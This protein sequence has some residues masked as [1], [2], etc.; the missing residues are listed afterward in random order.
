MPRLAPLP[1]LAYFSLWKDSVRT[2]A[3][4]RRYGF[5]TKSLPHNKSRLVRFRAESELSEPIWQSLQCA[6]SVADVCCVLFVHFHGG[7]FGLNKDHKVSPF[8]GDLLDKMFC[9][10]CG[11]NISHLVEIYGRGSVKWCIFCGAPVEGSSPPHASASDSHSRPKALSDPPAHSSSPTVSQLLATSLSHPSRASSSH[12]LREEPELADDETKESPRD[13]EATPT[14]LSESP[15]Q[16]VE[17]GTCG[18]RCPCGRDRE[19]SRRGVQWY[20]MHPPTVVSSLRAGCTYFMFL[21][22]R[23]DSP[24]IFIRWG[25][26]ERSGAHLTHTAHRSCWRLPVIRC[27]KYART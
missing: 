1:S 22:F 21:S 10:Q 11:K 27:A 26:R 6:I 15:A 24:L 8:S 23:L 19:Y 17:S 12:S 9:S 13:A 3:I 16:M 25:R 14:A 20:N 5:R 2:V 7:P 4:A 18:Q